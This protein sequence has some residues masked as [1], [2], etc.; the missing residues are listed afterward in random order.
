MRTLVRLYENAG[1]FN[2][3]FEFALLFIRSFFKY[4]DHYGAID[5]E[6]AFSFAFHLI[7]FSCL[8][9]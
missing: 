8:L 7:P 5:F 4:D 9:F 1:G 3:D 6:Y 2:F